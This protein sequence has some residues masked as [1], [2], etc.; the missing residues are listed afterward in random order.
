MNKELS[1]FSAKVIALNWL[2]NNVAC[3]HRQPLWPTN[4]RLPP[5]S[6]WRLLDPEVQSL[7]EQLMKVANEPEPTKDL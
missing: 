5:R 2:R 6:K 4:L 1:L 7:A 3:N